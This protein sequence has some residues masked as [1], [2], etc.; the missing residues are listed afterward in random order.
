[1]SRVCNVLARQLDISKRGT[2]GNNRNAMI[3]IVALVALVAFVPMI[4][5]TRLM[6]LRGEQ[7]GCFLNRVFRAGGANVVGAAVQA[8]HVSQAIEA[9]EYV[10]WRGP[11]DTNFFTAVGAIRGGREQRFWFVHGVFFRAN[12][13]AKSGLPPYL[14]AAL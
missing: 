10:A 12:Q 1:M 11:L 9:T 3:V 2:A 7:A 8:F 14:D 6:V 13:N 4:V 5:T